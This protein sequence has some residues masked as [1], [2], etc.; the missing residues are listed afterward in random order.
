MKTITIV[1][2]FI[3][4]SLELRCQWATDPNVN[5][6]I[7]TASNDQ[8]L[9]NI[10]SDGAGGAIITWED[11]RNGGNYDVYTQRINFAGFV[12]WSSNGVPIATVT[13]DQS[14]PVIIEDG[15]GGAIIAW[16]DVRNGNFLDIYVQKINSNG[17][18]QWT[19]NGISVCSAFNNQH[20]PT[21]I[22]DGSGGAI[23]TWQDRRDGGLDL[24]IYA[25]H[26]NSSGIVSWTTDGVA[27][28]TSVSEQENPTIASDGQGGAII[29]WQDNRNGTYLSKDYDI[30]VQRINA[31]GS[32]LWTTN[33]ISICNLTGN[34]VFP[35]ILNSRTE[36]VIITWFDAR[37]L[38]ELDIYA[39]RINLN[40][41]SLWTVNGVAICNATNWQQ[42]PVLV[43]DGE[44]GAIITWQDYRNG[45]YD[46]YT[47]KIDV[48]GSIKWDSDGVSISTMNNAQISPS[49]TS[50]GAGGA[51]IAWEDSR[52]EVDSDIY[53][54]LIN[55]GGIVQ[56]M[57]NGLPIS[58][59][60]SRQ[61][62]PS[63]T[64][65]G[66]GGAIITWFDPRNGL[67]PD[68]YAQ[69]VSH[70]GQLGVVTSIEEDIT[71]LPESFRLEQNYPNPFN[72]ET[73]I[74]WR[75]PVGSHQAIKVFDVL[76]N[77]IATLVDE[78]KPA[79][80]YE[81]EFNVAHESLRVI[82]SGVYFCR[83]KTENFSKT[84]KMLY[85]K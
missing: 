37:N 28:C 19:I 3:V 52:N 54:Q 23:I 16:N 34:Q 14:M 77:E 62:L 80:R 11:F 60:T 17:V 69:Q 81:V 25:Q 43:S 45:N 39:Q 64:S 65:D 53:A 85:L 58:T 72:P 26:I 57:D 13:N 83:L 44:G 71:S 22:S 68:I 70:N 74:S 56:W 79:G 10:I 66:A 49:I 73:K 84:I 2:L 18:V 1:F 38:N 29:T 8:A 47:Q 59:V 78:Y 5:N 20:N 46:V 4:Y 21:I 40:G 12:V 42:F 76:G 51:I 50:D 31:S 36:E 15:A 9:P 24:D 7:C 35:N 82:T 67:T 61:S 33:G 27:I 55:S 41:D 30:Y 6:P 48:F 32:V 75:S 63:I